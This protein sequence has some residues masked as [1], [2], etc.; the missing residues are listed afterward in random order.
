MITTK[1][2]TLAGVATA[3]VLLAQSLALPALA[4]SATRL[5]AA[6]AAAVAKS[7]A[8]AAAAIYGGDTAKITGCHAVRGGSYTCQVLLI[9]VHSSS[10]C[11]W[12]DTIRLVKG[13]PTVV[14]YTAAHCTN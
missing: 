7:D 12:T 8:M 4:A 6:S 1:N 5:T 3:A 11:R 9:P 2:Q 14:K 13:K 10:R